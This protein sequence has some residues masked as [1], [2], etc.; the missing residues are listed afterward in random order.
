MIR[1]NALEISGLLIDELKGPSVRPYQPPGLWEELAKGDEPNKAYE[2]S[3]GRDLYRRGIYTFWKRSIHYPAF[4]IL[5]A[6]NRETCTSSRPTT[7][8]PQQALALLND[9]TMIEAARAFA[10]SVLRSGC[11]RRDVPFLPAKGSPNDSLRETDFYVLL[12]FAFQR[13]VAR[14]GNS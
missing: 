10:E 4:A 3:H 9:P 1:D 12:Q 2:Q 11:D 7:N 14:R 6:P 13:A 8:T 5:D